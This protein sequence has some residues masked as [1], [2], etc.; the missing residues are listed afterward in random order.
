MVARVIFHSKISLFVTTFYCL[1][2]TDWM[3]ALVYF[4]IYATI[5]RPRVLLM[6][7][8]RLGYFTDYVDWDNL[9]LCRY[10]YDVFTFGLLAF[11]LY[12]WDEGI[13]ATAVIVVVGQ[14]YY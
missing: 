5:Q 1:F 3:S 7:W 6:L 2:L 11:S 10:L 13:F 12:A 4:L 9:D 8:N 14:A